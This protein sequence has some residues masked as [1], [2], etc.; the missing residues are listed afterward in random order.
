M[1]LHPQLGVASDTGFLGRK[2][3]LIET[4]LKQDI[5]IPMIDG[6]Y[7][8]KASIEGYLQNRR[9]PRS[10]ITTLI[11][12]I[13][14][15][16]AVNAEKC[17]VDDFLGL[18]IRKT[19]G[20]TGNK[21]FTLAWMYTHYLLPFYLEDFQKPDPRKD[22]ALAPAD[23]AAYDWNKMMREDINSLDVFEN[24]VKSI[25]KSKYP[26]K[27]MDTIK[28]GEKTPA[29]LHCLDIINNVYSKPKIILIRNP[30]EVYEAKREIWNNSR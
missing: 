1:N 19:L 21:S 20:E 4:F 2:C 8:N 13:D 22:R 5:H 16:V 3:S 17:I 23:L 6:K 26:E 27:N 7:I 14:L 29:H 30:I 15:S 28:V 25:I 12:Y 11:G 18:T 9:E 10:Y 24:M